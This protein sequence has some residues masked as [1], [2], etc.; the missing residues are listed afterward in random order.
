MIRKKEIPQS[1]NNRTEEYNTK[2]R[3]RTVISKHDS[4]HHNSQRKLSVER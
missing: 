4:S 1:D 3:P 2:A